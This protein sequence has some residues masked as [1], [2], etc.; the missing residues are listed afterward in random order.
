MPPQFSGIAEELG[1]WSDTSLHVRG[2]LGIEDGEIA[3]GAALR[4]GLSQPWVVGPTPNSILGDNT[5]PSGDAR[6]SGRLLGLTPD[7]E[8]VAGAARLTVDLPTLS[9]SLDFSEF[10]NWPVDTPPGTKG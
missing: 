4:N 9:G 8:T 6:W 7:A 1:P 2:A 3:F 5:A 10:K